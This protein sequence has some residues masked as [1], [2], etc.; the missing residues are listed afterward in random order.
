MGSFFSPDGLTFACRRII[1]RARR[2]EKGVRPGQ[3]IKKGGIMWHKIF[4]ATEII[5]GITRHGIFWRGLLLLLI[6]GLI[7][8]EPYPATLAMSVI[9]GWGL[10]AGGVWTAVSAFHLPRRRWAWLL[11]GIFMGAAGI[12]LL[13]NPEAELLAFAWSCAAL[14]L[15]GGVIGIAAAL[16][17]H[18]SS[19]LTMFCFFSSLIGI[20]LG[21][22]LFLCPLSGMT[23]LFWILGLMLAVQGVSM[24]IYSFRI[25]TPDRREE[26]S[27][28][29]ECDAGNTRTSKK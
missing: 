10:A 3:H 29:D 21:M 28:M 15:S 17:S 19:G 1:L 22:L 13:V 5:G 26:S 4:S 24:M 18:D 12:L 6:G 25:P 14:M 7:A 9:F 27:G 8:F 23:E 11:Y 16:A 2:P 20:L